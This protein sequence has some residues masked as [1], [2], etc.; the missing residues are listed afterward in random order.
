MSSKSKW[1]IAGLGMMA[2][3]ATAA[4]GFFSTTTLILGS[5]FVGIGMCILLFLG[6]WE[7][8]GWGAEFVR[9][10]NDQLSKYEIDEK[11]TWDENGRK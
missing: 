9:K 1:A 4:I 2:T 10:H 8:G 5:L 7:V 11:M 3:G 6:T